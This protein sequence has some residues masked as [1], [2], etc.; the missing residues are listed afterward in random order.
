MFA[1]CLE[2]LFVLIINPPTLL[3]T[4]STSLCTYRSVPICIIPRFWAPRPIHLSVEFF[5]LS[6]QP[7]QSATLISICAR[8]GEEGKF[9]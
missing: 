3:A 1:Y 6:H 2:F 8:K 9:S 7:S 5:N 4:Y